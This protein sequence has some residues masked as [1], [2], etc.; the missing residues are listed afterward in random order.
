MPNLLTPLVQR[1]VS[2]FGL[3]PVTA[4]E[5]EFYLLHSEDGDRVS[6][7]W[8][9]LTRMCNDAGIQLY[10]FSTEDGQG[11]YEVSL[12]PHA[13][14]LSTVEDT[15][16]LKTLITKAASSQGMTADFSAKPFADRPGSGLHIHI[17]LNDAD[18]KN[19][20]YKDDVLTNAPLRHSIGGLL[21]WLPDCMT[22]FAPHEDSYKR[23]TEKTNAP[24]TVSWGANNRTVAIRLPMTAHGNKRIEHR[25]AGADADPAMVMAVILAA[26]HDGLTRSCEPGEQIY[27]DASLAMYHL[28]PLPRSY[29]EAVQLFMNSTKIPAYF[30][31]SGLAPA[32]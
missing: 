16:T 15:L 11:Q 8:D 31:A 19:V 22:V 5:I 32:R 3:H 29:E 25:V 6:P 1:I 13:D 28:L 7:F 21:E 26:L 20:Y 24:L 2:D 17:H 27:G 10:N 9:A 30:S 18:S 12:A 4:S 14:P 23:F